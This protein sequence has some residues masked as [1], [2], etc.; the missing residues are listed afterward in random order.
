MGVQVAIT[1]SEQ[2]KPSYTV[3]TVLAPAFAV[4]AGECVLWIGNDFDGSKHTH[5]VGV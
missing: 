4:A 3:S 2:L 1:L 5:N